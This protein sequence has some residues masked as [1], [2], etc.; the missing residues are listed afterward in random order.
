MVAAVLCAAL[1]GACTTP[2]APGAPASDHASPATATATATAT[3]GESALT[4]KLVAI[5]DFHGHLQSPGVFAENLLVPRAQ[6]PRVG[7]AVHLAAR[8]AEIA[9]SN[10]HHVVVGAGD[11]VSASPMISALFHDE[12]A[13]EALNRIGLEF[14]AVGNHEFDRGL[15]ELLRLQRGGCLVRDGR[16]HP[17]SCRGAEVGTPAPFEG[18]RFQ[19]LAANVVAEASGEPVLPAYGVK[20]FDGVPVAF[21]GMTLEATAAS[22]APDGVAGLVFRDEADTVN[23]L[24]PVL[25][26]QGMEA[27]VVLLHQGGAQTAGPTDINGCD[28]GLAGSALAGIVARLDDAVDLVLSG[29]THAAYNCSASTIEV[30]RDDGA[31]GAATRQSRPGGLPNAAGRLLPV[32][33]A[34]A[35]GRVV[36][37]IDLRI[38]R[39]TRDV[40]AVAITNRLVNHGDTNSTKLAGSPV[41]RLV[42]GYEA[43]ARPIAARVVGTIPAELPNKADAA[44]NMPAGELVAD[45]YLTATGPADRGGAELAFTNPGGIRSPGFTWRASGAERDGEVTYGEAFTVQPFGNTLWTISLGA[46]QLRD[47]LEQQFA[48]CHGQDRSRILLPSRGV[49][50]AWKADAA[51]GQRI[52][53]LRIAGADGAPDLRIID[54]AGALLV[55]P[56][57]SFRVTVNSFLAAGGNNFSVFAA[58]IDRYMG[59]TDLDALVEHLGRLGHDT[60]TASAGARGGPASPGVPRIRRLD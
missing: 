21:I 22:V 23:A 49:S 19:W 35:Y 16:P 17:T 4:V 10:P 37:D 5:N 27:I 56:S 53:D 34:S 52:R 28:G 57:R 14:S 9:A 41:A 54:D 58:G 43:L 29:H 55:D 11:L 44:G 36:S 26:A 1:S 45:A 42:A 38:D 51:C 60:A 3:A 8:V 31:T 40:V 33:S 39:K 12:P 18:A 20:T 46:A 32:A 2:T 59:G 47:A 30:A 25:R 15:A 24:V 48:G 50:Y 6:R 7:G 13:V